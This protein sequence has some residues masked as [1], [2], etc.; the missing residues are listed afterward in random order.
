MWLW[1]VLI[2]IVNKGRLLI[3]C[4]RQVAIL[5]LQTPV[6]DNANQQPALCFPAINNRSW[7]LFDTETHYIACFREKTLSAP[8]AAKL[9]ALCPTRTDYY[10]K[11]YL[12]GII[13]CPNAYAQN[14]TTHPNL[15]TSPPQH[16]PTSPPP[17]APRASQ[18]RP[19]APKPNDPS[20]PDSSP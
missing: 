17:P 20:P 8:I 9:H 1:T 3:A 18:S 2:L 19:A 7:I 10:T 5:Y 12:P 15:T 11:E 4:V 14:N 6:L 16:P 13:C